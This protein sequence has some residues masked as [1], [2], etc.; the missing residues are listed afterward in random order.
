[1]KKI[2][3]VFFLFLL[4]S[5]KTFA[6]NNLPPVYE[7][8]T[9]TAVANFPDSSCQVLE[10]AE[11]KY[12]IEQV[13]QFP[14]ATKFHS[15]TGINHSVNTYWVRFRIKNDMIHEAKISFQGYI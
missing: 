1:M 5:V 7:I 13:S 11:G 2:F 15:N 12:T 6:Q 4:L 3:L 9:D 14:L 10:D 8:K